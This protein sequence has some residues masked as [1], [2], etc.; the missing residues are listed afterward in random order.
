VGKKKAV[1]VRRTIN[2][3]FLQARGKKGAVGAELGGK[4]RDCILQTREND[5]KK[6]KGIT[7]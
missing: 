2:F 6:G 4:G 5:K 7:C 1:K 3:L